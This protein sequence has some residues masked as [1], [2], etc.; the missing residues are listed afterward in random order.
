VDE[1]RDEVSDGTR[2]SSQD[3]RSRVRTSPL[4]SAGGL[5]AG[6]ET[7]AGTSPHRSASSPARTRRSTGIRRALRRLVDDGDRDTVRTLCH[8]AV[9]A[10]INRQERAVLDAIEVVHDDFETRVDLLQ[11]L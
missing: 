7:P 8:P 4:P 3:L 5:R 11:H 9:V 10:E 6:A 1:P 2:P